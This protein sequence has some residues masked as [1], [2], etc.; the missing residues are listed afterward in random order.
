MD[1]RAFA[2]RYGVSALVV[3]ALALVVAL[4]PGNADPSDLATGPGGSTVEDGAGGSVAGSTPG[5]AGTGASGV[6]AGGAVGGGG[7]SAGGGQAGAAGGGGSAGAGP[8]A[9]AG[10]ALGEGPQCG[11][12]GRQLGI[13]AYMPPCARWDGG[14]NGGATEDGVTADQ[15]VVVRYLPQLDPGTQAILQSAN[16]ADDA[17]T[18]RRAYETF[19]RYSNLHYQ[20]YGREVVFQ[21]FVAS[22]PSESDEAMKADA[23][24]IAE[25]IRPFAVIE[26]NPAAPMPPVLIRELGVRGVLC[27]CSTSAPAQYYAELGEHVFSSLPTMDEYAINAA[28]YI[29]KKLAGKPAVN[30]GD[31]FNPVQS[32]QDDTRRFGL[33]Y[34]NGARG[35]VYPEGE[36]ARQAFVR[37][38]ARYGLRFEV[39]IGYIYDPGRNQQDVTNMIAQMKDAGVTTI[40]PAWDPLYP[41]L[42]TR[43]ATNQLYFPEWFI[44]GTGL[45][46]TITGGRLYDQQQWRHAFGIS[47]LWVPWATVANSSGY[48]E[49]HHMRPQDPP[50][51]EGVLVN[52]YRARIQTLFR[53]IHLSGPTLTREGFAAAQYSYPPTGGTAGL[54]LVYLTPEFPT[55]IKDFSEVWWDADTRGPDERGEVANGM[56]RRADGGRRYQPGQWPTGDPSRANGATVSD[57]PEGGGDYPHEA[58]GHQHDSDQRCLTCS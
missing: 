11:P 4:L 41:I 10:F 3:A 46:D 14:D 12:D 1:W 55:E 35:T 6:A 36:Q 49:Y 37:E 21:D 20:T 33:I 28:E 26:G 39:E 5:G 43:E 27:M 31:E 45:S 52:I 8:A 53:G 13:S 44:I 9:A 40:V 38:F 30:A 32:F 54:P 42:I 16:L 7:G 24:L 57:T 29:A 18:I 34:F 56:M 25:E 58:D 48:R 23:L 17:E 19:F 22:G 50:G 15:V 47:P 51:A 2:E